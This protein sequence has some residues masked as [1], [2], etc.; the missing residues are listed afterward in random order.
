MKEWWNKIKGSKGSVWLLLLLLLGAALM[1][2]P[3]AEDASLA[4][5]EEEKRISATLSMIAG[6]GESR[7]AIYYA[8]TENAFG[9]AQK[10][11]RGAV[12]VSRGANDISVKLQL[13]RA[14]QTLLQL[15]ASAIDIF[16]MEETE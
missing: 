5:T 16:P 4:M 2:S 11:P 1:L 15:P 7:I 6:A 12:I 10:T 3:L 9:S 14:A 13:L 8:P